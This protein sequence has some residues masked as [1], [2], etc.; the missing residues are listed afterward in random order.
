MAYYETGADVFTAAK[1]GQPLSTERK[2]L[3]GSIEPITIWEFRSY[4]HA[5][6]AALTLE[7]MH[8]L[9]SENLCDVLAVDSRK[10][11]EITRLKE[12]IE[13]LTKQVSGVN[14]KEFYEYE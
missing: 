7:Q 5:D 8:K 4:G 1:P 2:N 12:E 11:S 6:Y 14:L 10:D 3:T 13:R 9:Q